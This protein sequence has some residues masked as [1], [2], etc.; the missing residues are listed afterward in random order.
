MGCGKAGVEAPTRRGRE[1]SEAVAVI[2]VLAQ[3][4]SSGSGDEVVRFWMY[5][6]A[7]VNVIYS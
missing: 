7:R 3:C 2:R 5:F 4:G 6:K 1:P